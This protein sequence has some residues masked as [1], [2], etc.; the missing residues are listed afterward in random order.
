[1]ATRRDGAIVGKGGGD[2]GW[3]FESTISRRSAVF[4]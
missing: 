1:M 4:L 3:G 2:A